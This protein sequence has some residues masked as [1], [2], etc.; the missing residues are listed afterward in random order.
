MT[1][2]VSKLTSNTRQL[3][4]FSPAAE[5]SLQEISRSLS[6]QITV[7][8]FKNRYAGT[9]AI[10]KFIG[11]GA[12]LA[13]SIAIPNL[14]LVLKPFL[15]E[16][17]KEEREAWKR[18]NIPYLKRS[19]KRLERQKLVRIKFMGDEQVVEVTAAG[20][21]KILKYALQ[22]LTIKKPGSWNG[23]WTIVIYDIPEDLAPVRDSLRH[24]LEQLGFY[25]LQESTYLHAYP[26]DK[27]VTF[28]REYLGVGEYVR[29]TKVVKIES[30]RLFRDF[31]GV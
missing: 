25:P 12:F 19:I 6:R 7:D 28:L 26:C 11:A 24:Y 21:R 22:N 5:K 31:F 18:F 13:A 27:E 16:N 29:I 2:S 15:D 9:A 10:L 4:T 3:L 1:K 17:A 20:Q 14:P 30:D 8:D 23:T